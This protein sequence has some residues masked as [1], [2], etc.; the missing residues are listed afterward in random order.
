MGNLQDGEI[1]YSDLVFTSNKADIEQYS[2]KPGDLLFNRTNSAEKVGKVS[3][4]RRAEPCIFAGYLVR[5]R[6]IYCDSDFVNYVMNSHY[7]WEFCQSV[8][9][10]AVNQSNISASKFVQ[11]LI[12]LPPISEQKLIVSKVKELFSYIDAIGKASE[13]I[14]N[15]AESIDKKIL[16]LAIRGQLAPQ[17]PKDE[18]ASELLK[19]IEAAKRAKAGGRVSSRAA[20]DRPA[21]EIDPPFDIP[22][23]WEWVRLGAILLP[24]ETKRPTGETF[25]YIDIDA[26]DNKANI[27]LSPKCLPVVNAPSRASRGLRTGDTLF[28]VV[29]PY[30]RNIAYISDSLSNC[31]ASTGF[32]VCRP[33]EAVEPRFLFKLLLSDYVVNGLNA[34]MKGDN[35]P[36][37]RVE[38]LQD[39]PVPLPP[40]AEQKRIVSKIDELRAMT[41]S[42]TT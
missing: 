38:H 19:R 33:S 11:F 27:V 15:T 42:L 16:A 13:G 37:I 24:L 8:K 20:S 9:S 17:D 40:L 7:Q 35:S 39:Y 22:D 30:L 5:F 14:A 12:P 10:D 25:R 28:S 23:S 36:S 18:P 1:D 4:F 41:K 32:Y 6:P 21:Y 3:I 2:L 26:I 31:I 34:F 29:R